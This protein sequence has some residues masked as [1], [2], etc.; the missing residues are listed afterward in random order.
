MKEP[1]YEKGYP[2]F[3][4]VNRE[5][6]QERYHEYMKRRMREEDDRA[7]FTLT[8]EKDGE[9]LVLPFPVELLNHMGW[10]IGDTLLW[11]ITQD[12]NVSV[13]KKED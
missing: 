4:A 8:V 5:E 13:R 7:K 10:D 11:E 6:P 12:G 9:E 1:V 3:E 2:S